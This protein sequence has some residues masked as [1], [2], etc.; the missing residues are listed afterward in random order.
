MQPAADLTPSRGA[1]AAALGLAIALVMPQNVTLS[2]TIVPPPSAMQPAGRVLMLDPSIVVTPIGSHWHHANYLAWA[3]QH[4]RYGEIEATAAQIGAGS[5]YARWVPAALSLAIEQLDATA[6]AYAQMGRCR[7]LGT[8]LRR[9][10]RE[11]PSGRAAMRGVS[12]GSFVCGTGK[13]EMIKELG[14]IDA[15]RTAMRLLAAQRYA[16]RTIEIAQAIAFGDH[17][18]A[19][20][21]CGAIERD[22]PMP[23]VCLAEACRAGELSV[24]EVLLPFGDAEA[25]AAC[26]RAGVT[27]LGGVAYATGSWRTHPAD[28]VHVHPDAPPMLDAQRIFIEW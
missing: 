13:R 10:E 4:R 7:E 6:A 23:P 11:W 18:S 16:E 8:F 2:S 15:Y 24:A 12:C 25:R 3:I 27:F 20:A 19:L 5:P 17:A 22:G 26:A 28:L 14:G 21:S 9:I 1:L